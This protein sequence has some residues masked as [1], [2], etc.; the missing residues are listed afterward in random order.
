MATCDMLLALLGEIQAGV[1][2]TAALSNVF[3]PSG[4]TQ[5]KDIADAA[6]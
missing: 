3:P 2:P 4:H 1:K 5:F 6:G